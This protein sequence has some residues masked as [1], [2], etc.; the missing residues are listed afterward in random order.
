MCI[1]FLLL[2]S[3][4]LV[5]DVLAEGRRES[6][7]LTVSAF[8]KDYI[9]T[10]IVHQEKKVKITEEDVSRG[11]VEIQAATIVELTTN[12]RMGCVLAFDTVEKGI[13]KEVLVRGQFGETKMGPDG[14]VIILKGERRFSLKLDYKFILDEIK[15]GEYP[16]PLL[17]TISQ[18]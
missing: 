9:K 1:S 7:T 14:G 3:F 16:W 6:T 5:N 11:Y 8:V 13:F 4:F 12:S 18:M 10:N 17:L 15:P 2:S